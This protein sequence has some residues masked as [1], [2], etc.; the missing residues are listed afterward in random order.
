ML[1]L[2]AFVGLSQLIFAFLYF[3][4]LRGKSPSWKGPT[5]QAKKAFSTEPPNVAVILSL[6]GSDP[7]LR[8]NMRLLT[9]QDYSNYH[10]YIVVDSPEDRAW[11]D[12]REWMQDAPNRIT[13]WSL[14]NRVE[15]CSLKCSALAEALERYGSAND[16]VAFIDG[17]ACPHKTW[18]RDLTQPLIDD[19][20]GV[21]AGNRWYVP[22]R[23]TM[24][25]MARYF[26][27]IGAVV[28]VWW[29]GL[30]WGGSM[31]MRW[32][33]VV[34]VELIEALRHAFV[35]DGAVIQ[36][37]R[38][39]GYR[40]HFEPSVIM[41]NREDIAVSHFIPWSARQ[42][43]AARSSGAGWAIVLFHAA[44]IC[45]SVCVPVVLL[46]ASIIQANPTAMLLNAGSIVSHWL[47]ALLASLLVEVGMRYRLEQNEQLPNRFTLPFI[48]MWLPGIVASHFLYWIC[49]FRAQFARRLSWRGID[50][51]VLRSGEVRMREYRPYVEP[52]SDH[53]VESLV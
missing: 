31:A 26:W 11:L 28:Q 47:I 18:I 20:V 22:S 3:M 23:L 49:L 27:N 19:S 44:M 42:L 12:V 7:D 40:A 36:Q 39:H 35:D 38:K 33:T 10:I 41:P 21:S 8:Q 13:A 1:G 17:D 6:R 46:V 4:V 45:A 2:V 9:F 48:A 15:T 37:I 5:S 24:G 51:D 16:I 53:R 30:T 14:E 32:N 50:Y 43:V 52:K 34:D 25:S 29:N